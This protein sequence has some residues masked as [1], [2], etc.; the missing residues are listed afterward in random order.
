[1]TVRRVAATT[2]VIPE[3]AVEQLAEGDLRTRVEVSVARFLDVVSRHRT[4]WLAAISAGGMGRDADVNRVLG[5]AEEVAA[6][7]RA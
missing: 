3:V 5:E 1:M 4:S 6:D 2:L 7:S